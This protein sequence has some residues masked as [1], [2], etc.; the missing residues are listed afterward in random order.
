PSPVLVGALVTLT[1][2]R[3]PDLTRPISNQAS[4]LLC[5]N[6][7]RFDPSD[8]K[9]GSSTSHKQCLEHDLTS[10]PRPLG[11]LLM[12]PLSV[13]LGAPAALTSNPQRSRS[14]AEGKGF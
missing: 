10:E 1:S 8:F 9:A 12:P 5:Q 3:E 4:N 6:L 13:A 7:H 11:P 2:C 14:R